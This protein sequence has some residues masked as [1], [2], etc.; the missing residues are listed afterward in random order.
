M[1][2]FGTVLLFTDTKCLYD[3]A[4][5][6]G[7]AVV[8]EVAVSSAVEKAV[9]CGVGLTVTDTACAVMRDGL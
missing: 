2:R 1:E 6:R 3:G 7:V 9:A 5:L 8:V 4:A